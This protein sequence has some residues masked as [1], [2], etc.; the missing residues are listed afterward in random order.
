MK[1]NKFPPDSDEERIQNVISDSE[2]QTEDEA[3][4]KDRAASQNEF[5]MPIEVFTEVGPSV[6]KW[7]LEVLF[8]S[9]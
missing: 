8:D 6:C 5:D 9:Q 3:V 1:Q 2:Q 7:I 4:A